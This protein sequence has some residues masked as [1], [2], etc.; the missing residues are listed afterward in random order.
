[1]KI[2]CLA[3]NYAQHN[4]EMDRTLSTTEPT[5]FFKPDSSILKDGKPFFVPDF[6]ERFEYEGELVVRI[7]R[8]GKNISKKFAHRYYDAV[9]VGI[10]MTARDLQ[11]QLISQGRPWELSKG[12]DH[13]A[14]LGEFIPV[15]QLDCEVAELSFSLH[16]N[17]EEVQRAHSSEMIH[18]IDDI[19][20][21]VSQ[22][23]TLK[24]GDLIFTGT[25]AGVGQISINDHLQGFLK[26]RKVLDFHIK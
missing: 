25:P 18:Q 7:N 26:D 15:E 23:Y 8:L 17:G 3:W 22:Y 13:S 11:E 21:Y 12:F 10:D 4:K 16:K 5:L 19:I 9:T 6:A 14:I 2:I 24:I 1:M 20:A